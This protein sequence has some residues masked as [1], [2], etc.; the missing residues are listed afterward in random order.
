MNTTSPVLAV[1]LVALS[2]ASGLAAE[3]KS[4]LTN[5]IKKL[6]DQP[7]YSWTISQKTEG[8]ETASRRDGK[9]E[10]KAEKSGLVLVK[11]ASGEN[12]YEV[13][14]KGEKVIVNFNEDWIAPS[15]LPIDEGRIEQ[16][17]KALKTT[18]IDQANSLIEKSKEWKQEQ[19][20][21][22]SAALDPES[23][24]ASFTQLGRRAKEA[25]A[26][27][28]SLRFWTK[29]GQL[30]KYEVKVTGKITVGSDKREVEISRTTTVEIK[31]VGSTKI[32]LPEGARNRLS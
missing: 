1:S 21:E 30:A 25:T 29:D 19:G 6:A 10:G 31:D 28:G 14:F 5:A 15:E 23:A 13:A 24:L 18:P 27:T 3:P 9:I 12:A 32:S 20:G 7:S 26:A 17:L 16:R 8:S 2:L 4:E 22:Y 11:T